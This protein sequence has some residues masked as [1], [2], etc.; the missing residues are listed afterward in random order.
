MLRNLLVH[1]LMLIL[2]TESMLCLSH[3]FSHI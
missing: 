3:L 2:S 1:L